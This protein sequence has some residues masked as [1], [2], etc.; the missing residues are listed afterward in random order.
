MQQSIV[1]LS[2][3]MVKEREN[4]KASQLVYFTLYV[5][6]AFMSQK[7][8]WEIILEM[9]TTIFISL[10]L[11]FTSKIHNLIF[12]IRKFYFRMIYVCKILFI[13]NFAFDFILGWG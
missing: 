3:K 13:I 11:L 10:K 1:W 4:L 8:L 7:M 2:M 5:K 12:V 9:G 6:N